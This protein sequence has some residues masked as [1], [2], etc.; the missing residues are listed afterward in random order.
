MPVNDAPI[1]T[2]ATVVTAEDTAVDLTL[3]GVDADV[4]RSRSTWWT[5][6]SVAR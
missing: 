2:P 4:T 5:Y 6:R 3:S 1:A